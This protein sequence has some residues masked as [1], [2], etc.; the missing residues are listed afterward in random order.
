MSKKLKLSVK[1]LL[2]SAENDLQQH[3]VLFKP[4]LIGSC[5]LSVQHAITAEATIEIL[6]RMLHGSC[7]AV[8]EGQ[9]YTQDLFERLAWLKRAN[10]EGRF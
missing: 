4:G 9:P 3:K 10:K 1:W 7:G 8:D 6:E 5:Q 2:E